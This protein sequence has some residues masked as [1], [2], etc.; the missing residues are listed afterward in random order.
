MN[1]IQEQL[2]IDFWDSVLSAIAVIP[3][4]ET[5]VDTAVKIN[6]VLKRRRK[7]IDLADLFIAATEMTRNLPVATLNKKKL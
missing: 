2:K 1:C 3:F 5:C 7:Q 4:N 6:T